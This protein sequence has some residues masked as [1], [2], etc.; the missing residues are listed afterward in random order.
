M[1]TWLLDDEFRDVQSVDAPARHHLVEPFHERGLGPFDAL[2]AAQ[3]V[4]R[5]V[6]KVGDDES[7]I[8]GKR[9]CTTS[10]SPSLLTSMSKAT[11]T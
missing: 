6:G 1:S 3:L 11:R 5:A 4:E 9:A 10:L 8:C 7:R 2:A